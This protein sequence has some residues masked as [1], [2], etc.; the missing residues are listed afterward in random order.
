MAKGSEGAARRRRTGQPLLN[1]RG[2]NTDRE[3]EAAS[4]V[5]GL[6]VVHANDELPSAPRDRGRAG[7]DQEPLFRVAVADDGKSCSVRRTFEWLRIE[8]VA[9]GATAWITRWAEPFVIMAANLIAPDRGQLHDLSGANRPVPEPHGS[10]ARI[11][12]EGGVFT[13]GR[14]GRHHELKPDQ[15]AAGV[16]E[17]HHRLPRCDGRDELLARQPNG[18]NDLDFSPI[19]VNN[20]QRK[21]LGRD[22]LRW[23]HKLL[24]E[25]MIPCVPRCCSLINSAHPRGD[26]HGEIRGR[27]VALALLGPSLHFAKKMC[28]FAED[29]VNDPDAK[30][31]ERALLSVPLLGRRPIPC[32]RCT[33]AV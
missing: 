33:R 29:R 32:L 22:R 9:L 16:L 3:P 7:G 13:L 10:I 5:V 17:H 27:D 11:Y 2:P 4:I 23:H 14:R 15:A 26:S 28:P 30:T 18:P 25:D 1:G 8:I 19:P 21:S 20:R 12:I 6:G 24:A 31:Q